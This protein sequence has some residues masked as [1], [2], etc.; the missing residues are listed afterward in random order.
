MK[1]EAV[2]DESPTE[3]RHLQPDVTKTEHDSD[4]CPTVEVIVVEPRGEFGNLFPNT[5]QLERVNNHVSTD[6]HV[7]GSRESHCE[8]LIVN[9]SDVLPS[10]SSWCRGICDGFREHGAD[11]AQEVK[12]EDEVSTLTGSCL[13]CK[14]PLG[15][16]RI[17]YIVVAPEVKDTPE[18]MIVK[19]EWPT[20]AS[21]GAN[22][23]D[24]KH[25]PCP[26]SPSFLTAHLQFSASL[27]GPYDSIAAGTAS[28]D[29]DAGSYVEIPRMCR[30][31]VVVPQIIVRYPANSRTVRSYFVTVTY[32]HAG[33]IT[34]LD[35]R[36]DRV[37][38][39]RYF[40]VASK[41]NFPSEVETAVVHGYLAPAA[42]GAR[43]HARDRNFAIVDIEYPRSDGDGTVA[44]PSESNV[45]VDRVHKSSCIHRTQNDHNKAKAR[46]SRDWSLS[47]RKRAPADGSRTSGRR[48][49]ATSLNAE[50]CA[51][52]SV[53][54][55][56]AVQTDRVKY[57]RVIM[58]LA[59]ELGVAAC[60]HQLL[61]SVRQARYERR[62]MD[63]ILDTLID[64]GRAN[65]SRGISVVYETSAQFRETCVAQPDAAG[66]SDRYSTTLTKLLRREIG[67]AYF[68][69]KHSFAHDGGLRLDPSSASVV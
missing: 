59:N 35:T 53:F 22:D 6:Q 62:Y 65:E 56:R 43:A 67:S 47:R 3:C 58:R 45:A 52:I 16:Y 69:K 63:A 4:A 2:K 54:M 25:L 44:T 42:S 28:G 36:F 51:D 50:R 23:D 55:C 64:V 26:A 27:T 20:S 32:N 34:Q 57:A 14:M 49:A 8:G 11:E 38:E 37:P 1:T 10:A 29:V 41:P 33:E 21:A 17:P 31:P 61:H 13:E 60:V 18:E 9:G 46:W 15:E 19:S 24:V 30:I 40:V 12:T 39:G 7:S 68:H 48:V 66:A 5:G